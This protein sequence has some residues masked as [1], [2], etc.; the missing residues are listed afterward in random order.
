MSETHTHLSIRE[1][2]ARARSYKV[3]ANHNGAAP[4]LIGRLDP[5]I[6]DKAVS[7]LPASVYSI[8]ERQAP[9]SLVR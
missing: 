5:E 6:L 8:A 4:A 1:I 7:R 3:L 2:N 9:R